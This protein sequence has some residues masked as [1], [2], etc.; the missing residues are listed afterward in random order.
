MELMVM[1]DSTTKISSDLAPC[2]QAYLRR[3]HLLDEQRSRNTRSQRPTTLTLLAL[4][5]MNNYYQEDV[6]DLY[7]RISIVDIFPTSS[8]QTD[9]CTVRSPTEPN[10]KALPWS[11]TIPQG[12][13]LHHAPTSEPYNTGAYNKVH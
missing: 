8:S 5:W 9:L 1:T 6:H 4:Q 2:G 7:K 12:R 13:S 11:S 10:I 3:N